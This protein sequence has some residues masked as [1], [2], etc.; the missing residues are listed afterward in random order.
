MTNELVD[1][2]CIKVCV[3]D[4]DTGYCIGCGRS[5][6]EI[7][8]WAGLTADDKREVVARLPDRLSEMTAKRRRKGGRRAR[9]N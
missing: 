7:A 9:R 3:V 5:R 2:P 6:P 4:L 8:G 1:S